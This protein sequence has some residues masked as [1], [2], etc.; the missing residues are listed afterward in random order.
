[1]FVVWFCVG[2][3]WLVVAFAVLVDCL[4]FLVCGL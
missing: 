1:M 2:V 4:L 3:L